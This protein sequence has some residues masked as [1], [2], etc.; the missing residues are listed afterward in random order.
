[1][2]VSESIFMLNWTH[3]MNI[4]IILQKKETVQDTGVSERGR[5]ANDSKQIKPGEHYHTT[6]NPSLRA[7]TE[8]YSELSPFFSLD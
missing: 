4:H 3:D 6:S 1:M 8:S 5:E 7:K 2:S